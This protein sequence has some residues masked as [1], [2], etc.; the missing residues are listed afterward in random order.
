MYVSATAQAHYPRRASLFAPIAVSQLNG[1][2]Q[3]CHNGATIRLIGECPPDRQSF[4]RTLMAD[5]DVE[6]YKALRATIRQ[7]GTA[8]AWIFVAGL[9]AWAALTLATASA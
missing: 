6:E 5:R 2:Q 9:A 7:R 8:R 4:R 1:N 3:L